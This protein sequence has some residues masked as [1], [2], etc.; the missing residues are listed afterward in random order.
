MVTASDSSVNTVS[1]ERTGLGVLSFWCTT[2]KSRSGCQ[3]VEKEEKKEK[4]TEA[5]RTEK[6][7]GTAEE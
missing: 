6:K 5:E 1:G 2:E 7:G 3:R 4:A